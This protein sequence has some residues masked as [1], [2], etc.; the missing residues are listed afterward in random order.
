MKSLLHPMMPPALEEIVRGNGSSSF[1]LIVVRQLRPWLCPFYDGCYTNNNSRDIVVSGQGSSGVERSLSQPLFQHFKCDCSGAVQD[2]L[3]LRRFFTK[4]WGDKRR[5]EGRESV[6]D[7]ER[8]REKTPIEIINIVVNELTVRRL[9][10]NQS[11]VYINSCFLG[12]VFPIF[13]RYHMH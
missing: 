5:K 4:I 12:R 7:G 8:T 9:R 3:D 10:V 13:V 11:Y 6:R 1:L 2:Q